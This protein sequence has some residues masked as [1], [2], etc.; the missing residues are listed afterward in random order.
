MKKVRCLAAAF[1]I[2]LTLLSIVYIYSMAFPLTNDKL[3]L[4][5]AISDAYWQHTNIDVTVLEV[6]EAEKGLI[7]FFREESAR[8]TFGFA[9]FKRGLTMRYAYA[10]HHLEPIPYTSFVTAQS[11]AF[12]SENILIAGYNNIDEI[13]SFGVRFEVLKHIIMEVG[14]ENK[15][16]FIVEATLPIDSGQFFMAIPRSELFTLAGF[17]D[18]D[19]Y[20]VSHPYSHCILYDE[21]GN[22][23]TQHFYIEDVN[24][25]WT[26]GS[27]TSQGVNR[28]LIFFVLI[29]GAALARSLLKGRVQFSASEK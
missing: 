14:G 29:C 3:V 24:A 9:F 23:I 20:M 13:H 27:A 28:L 16:N 5:Q 11:F 19:D 8:Q 7:A 1:V 26:S 17:A 6:I 12:D 4:E 21:A 2:L 18:Y 22:D 10:E 25:G 15:R